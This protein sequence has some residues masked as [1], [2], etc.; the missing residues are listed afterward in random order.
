MYVCMYVCMKTAPI[1]GKMFT[2]S[3]KLLNMQEEVNDNLFLKLSIIRKTVNDGRI[4]LFV[5]FFSVLSLNHEVLYVRPV[6]KYNF[7]DSCKINW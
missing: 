3:K 7:F 1:K 6:G 2:I 5:L 4:N